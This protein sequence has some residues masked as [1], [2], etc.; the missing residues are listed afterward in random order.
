[1]TGRL[2]SPLVLITCSLLAVGCATT[3]RGSGETTTTPA[4]RA[5]ESDMRS[6]AYYHYT[7]AQTLAQ[8]GEFKEAIV[9]MQEAIKRDPSSAFLWTSLAQWY[10]RAESPG[11]AVSAARRAV[12]LAPSDVS[13]HVT[14]AELLRGQRQYPEAETGAGEGHRAEP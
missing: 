11:E 6:D 8:N 2:L 12:Q 5:G 13:T 9:A 4:F 10:A 7:V 14:L 1:M 3:G